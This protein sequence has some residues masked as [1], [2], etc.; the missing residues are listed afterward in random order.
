MFNYC[1]KLFAYIVLAFFIMER[2]IGTSFKSTQ[3]KSFKGVSIPELSSDPILIEKLSVDLIQSEIKKTPLNLPL[4]LLNYSP[5]S[6]KVG[7]GDKLFTFTVKRNDCL[8]HLLEELL[9]I[10][11]LKKL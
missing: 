7:P 4:S 9:L 3:I 1:L 2:T 11:Y 8:Q 10:L 6:Y 5:E